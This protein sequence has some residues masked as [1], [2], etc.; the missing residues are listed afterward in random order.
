LTFK[1]LAVTKRKKR[2]LL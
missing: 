1:L 2:Q